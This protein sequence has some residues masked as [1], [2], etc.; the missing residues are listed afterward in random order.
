M[1]GRKTYKGKYKPEHPEKYLGDV[2]NI[3]FRSL[4]ERKLMVRCDLNPNVI[5]WGS[6][7]IIVQYWSTVDKR[8]R[9]YFTDFVVKHKTK[10]GKIETL[11]IEVKPNKERFPPLP[12]KRKTQKTKTRY[13][14]EML[15]YKRNQ[16]KWAAASAYA[17]KRGMK[18]VVMDEYSLG[19]KKRGT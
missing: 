13:L 1:A 5:K 2:N 7:E 18:F 4:W 11:L 9:R 15:T 8:E 12:P 10:S 6:E 14:N 16:D 19:I 3:V 17:K